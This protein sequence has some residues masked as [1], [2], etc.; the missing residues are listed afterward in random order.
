MV[1][2]STIS[3]KLD[4]LVEQIVQLVQPQ[5][6]VLFGSVSRDQAHEASDADLLIV[7][8]EGTPRRLTAQRLYLELRG[9]ELPFDLL[10]VTPD[11]LEKHQ[12]NPGLIYAT[13]MKE[14]KELY[15]A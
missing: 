3:E 13:I 1:Q 7:V 12:N 2:A 5:R 9:I 6:I 10:V 8:P 14:G 4:H 11:L 15:A